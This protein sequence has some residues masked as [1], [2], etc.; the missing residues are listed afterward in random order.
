LKEVGLDLTKDMTAVFAGGHDKSVTAVKAGT[1]DAGFAFD[2][3]VNFQAIDRG[4]I[5][6]G[7][8]K[9]IGKSKPIPNSPLAVSTALPAS[10]VK[11]IK[12]VVPNI[13]T[14]YLQANQLCP[15]T[16]A[17]SLGGQN[18]WVV[19]NESFFQPIADVCKATNA[20]AC[21]PA[22]KN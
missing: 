22:K 17:C 5:K 15:A 18:A 2:D 3:M 21:Q 20:P 16:G 12:E 7:E 8:L 19:V 6:A 9:T 1:C 10:L 14:L 4:L 11:K 13:D